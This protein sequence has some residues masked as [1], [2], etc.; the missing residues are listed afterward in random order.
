MNSSIVIAA[1]FALCPLLNA[2]L[3]QS[4]PEQRTVA[5][6][7]KLAVAVTQWIPASDLDADLPG[8]PF[9]NWFK[10]V[11]GSRVE[12]GWQ[13]YECGEIRSAANAIEDWR[14]CV[15]VSAVLPDDRIV[16]LMITVGTFKKGLIGAPT[17]YFCV[18]ERRGE[19]YQVRRLRDLPTELSMPSGPSGPSGGLARGLAAVKL[20]EVNTPRVRLSGN[21]ANWVMAPVWSGG[22]FGRVLADEPPPAP[23]P[24][25]AESA[26]SKATSTAK[27][28]GASADP[29]PA[30]W[31]GDVINK[32]QPQYPAIA[33]R[34]NVSGAVSVR[35]SISEAGMVTEAKAVSGH[36]LLREAAEQAARQWVFRP[37]TFN[38]APVE[39][40]RVL[41]FVFSPPQ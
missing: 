12:V 34:L 32:V 3:T 17:F 13:I 36:P 23:A 8:I 33:R 41:M 4:S 18:I 7:E 6:L 30:A 27:D 5:A 20:P 39:T 21:N 15:E 14:A 11:V 9:G 26:S 25:R 10:Q 28:S 29:G 38:G 1:L 24:P 37:A 35:V 16:H 19:L 31:R 2:R 40:R 22:E